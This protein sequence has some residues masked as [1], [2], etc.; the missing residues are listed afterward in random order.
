MKHYLL[1]LFLG[2]VCWSFTIKNLGDDEYFMTTQSATTASVIS[3]RQ[4]ALLFAKNT[5]AT[6][7]NGKVAN[8]AK[9]YIEHNSEIG[10]SADDFMTETRMTANMLLQNVTV[11][12]ENVIQEKNGRYTV[13]ITLKL[14]K[15]EVLNTLCKKLAE[16]KVD[17]DTFR[18]EVFTD[19]WEKE[20]K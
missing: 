2:M 19:L 8:V 1:I 20:N 10:R 7:V 17:K 9:S 4:K 3:A 15:D 11:A 14:K 5:L 16:N 18:K 12:D 13:Y 6:M